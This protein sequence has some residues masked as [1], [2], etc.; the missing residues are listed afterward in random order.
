G[1]DGAMGF[2]ADLTVVGDLLFFRATDGVTGG[3]LWRSDGTTPRTF[4]VK[5]IRPRPHFR[6][7]QRLTALGALLFFPAHARSTRPGLWRSDGTEAGTVMVKDITPGSSYG[8]GPGSRPYD[9]T[10]VGGT[11]FFTA[12]DGVHGHELWKSDGTEAGTSLVKDINP[13]TSPLF[14]RP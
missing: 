11:L 9:L 5:D 2:E 1:S 14:P 7:P 4:L 13:S 10:A 8:Y 12:D 6:Y 3:E